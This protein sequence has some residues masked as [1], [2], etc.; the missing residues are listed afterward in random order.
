[1]LRVYYK[2]GETIVYDIEQDVHEY[3]LA[4]GWVHTATVD[5]KKWIAT[6]CNDYSKGIIHFDSIA[7]LVY[8]QKEIEDVTA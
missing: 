2:N 3:L 1:M 8:G 4:Y 5:P 6:L 7:E